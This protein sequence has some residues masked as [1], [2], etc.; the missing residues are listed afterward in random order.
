MRTTDPVHYSK[1]LRAWVVTAYEHVVQGFR[2][3]RLTGDRTKFLIDG[4]L[5]SCDRSA[6]KDFERIE[7][8]MMIN[9]EGAEHMRL[10]RLVQHSFTPA[11]LNAAR[12]SI[13]KAVQGLL[14]KVSHS[15]R[16]DIVSDYAKPL[17]TL[18]ICEF[19]GILPEDGPMLRQWSEA[20]GKFC[21]ATRDAV[22]VAAKAANDAAL[23]FERYMFKLIEDRRRWRTDD[24][25]G[26]LAA[27]REEG[28]LSTVEVSAQ[29]S[30]LFS[31]GHQTVID[32][33]CNGVH[34][35]LSHPEQLQALRAEPERIG[36]AVEEVLRYDSAVV[37]MNRTTAVDLEIDGRHISEGEAV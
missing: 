8:G 37:Y 2:D 9:K 22:H 15:R 1:T 19:M 35:Y 17:P 4:Q 13:E 21:G 16:L 28:Q 32:Q 31:A 10:R 18:V 33:L 20:K 36:P 7:R 29:C 14:D 27:S 24:L 6:V 25:I 26:V 3:H 34:A 30:S 5:G 23:N 12:P 11:R